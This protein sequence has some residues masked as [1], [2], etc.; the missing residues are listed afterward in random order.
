M[1]IVTVRVGLLPDIEFQMRFPSFPGDEVD[2]DD[3]V[4]IS[5]P[6]EDPGEIVVDGAEDV[7]GETVIEESQI[8]ESTFNSTVRRYICRSLVCFLMDERIRPFI[9]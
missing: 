1:I 4:A 9:I 2:A 6:A 5:T 7:Q 3:E 8:T